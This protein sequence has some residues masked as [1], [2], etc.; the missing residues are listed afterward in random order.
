MVYELSFLQAEATEP[1]ALAGAWQL[2]G[3]ALGRPAGRLS[4]AVFT[5]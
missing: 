3:G 1:S 4:E 2:P 5:G